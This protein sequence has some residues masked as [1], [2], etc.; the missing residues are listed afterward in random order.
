MCICRVHG[1]KGLA[2]GGIHL[3][4]FFFFFLQGH[5]NITLPIK[6]ELTTVCKH[7]NVQMKKHYSLSTDNIWFSPCIYQ[8][9]G[10]SLNLLISLSGYILSMGIPGCLT[11]QYGQCSDWSSEHISTINS[12][13]FSIIKVQ[14]RCT[15]R[16]A[17]LLYNSHYQ[18]V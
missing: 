4:K 13:M 2:E 7:I 15:D 8:Q 18:P 17:Q 14:L 11:S 5:K 12:Y 9:A 1:W 10:L 6:M 16:N 3:E